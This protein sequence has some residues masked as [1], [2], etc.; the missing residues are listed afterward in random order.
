MFRIRK[1]F[2]KILQKKRIN[3]KDFQLSTALNLQNFS[4]LIKL[5]ASCV[6]NE[7]YLCATG[8]KLFDI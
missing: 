1:I 7:N 8:K 6:V 5:G 2:W 4:S 3:R